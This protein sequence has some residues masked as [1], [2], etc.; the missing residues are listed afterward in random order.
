M[1]SV[2]DFLKKTIIT[3]I[4]NPP[5]SKFGLTIA[6]SGNGKVIAI[7]STENSEERSLVGVVY[8]FINDNDKWIQKSVLKSSIT[9]YYDSFGISLAINEDGS[10]LVIGACHHGSTI[11]RKRGA[12]FI[13]E[14]K[15]DEWILDEKIIENSIGRDSYFGW[16]IAINAAGDRLVVSDIAI[17]GTIF[18][19][20]KINKWTLDTILKNS[21]KEMKLFHN[22]WY[23][24]STGINSTGNIIVVASLFT[25]KDNDSRVGS[26]DIYKEINDK[27]RLIGNLIPNECNVDSHYG[28]SLDINDDVS[29]IIVSSINSNYKGK[30]H[31]GTVYIYR[32]KD[33]EW[34]LEDKL[35]PS[36]PNSY[37]NFGYCVRIA[38]KR[39][40]IIASTHNNK[41]N[42]SFVNVYDNDGSGW[43][44]KAMLIP[45]TGNE[46]FAIDAS[47][48]DDGRIISI[49]SF[50]FSIEDQIEKGIT[51]IYI[52]KREKN[53]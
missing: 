4:K 12:V 25:K 49:G 26:I 21:V 2:T 43:E 45:D 51:Y 9:N 18:I 29:I 27:W 31:V 20:K 48:N 50:I 22:D 53:E 42:K 17:S 39:E 46:R 33:F 38:R 13:Y 41:L 28:W 14:R 47:I 44:K 10:T 52:D 30:M 36:N 37:D 6:I 19:Y 23:G 15:E 16:S 8:V 34:I 40:R 35:Y 11:L 1:P 7:S 3:P 24:Y 5:Q 32:L